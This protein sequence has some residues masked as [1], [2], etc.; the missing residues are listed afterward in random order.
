MLAYDGN[1]GQY[2]FSGRRYGMKSS[3]PPR[4]RWKR[5]KTGGPVS[6]GGSWYI[7]LRLPIFLDQIREAYCQADFQT[8][9]TF[10]KEENHP[11]PFSERYEGGRPAGLLRSTCCRR[12]PH[13]SEPVADD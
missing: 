12:S 6:C 11:F 9:L 7:L 4:R 1:Y 8:S 5:A 3:I 2:L 10:W 13:S